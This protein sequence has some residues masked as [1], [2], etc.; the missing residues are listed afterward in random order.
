VKIA[1]FLHKRLCVV[2]DSLLRGGSRDVF[3]LVN[4]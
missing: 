1:I 3:Q 4:Y 2:F